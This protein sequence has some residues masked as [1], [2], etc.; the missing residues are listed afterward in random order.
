MQPFRKHT[1]K[2]APLYRANI[3]TDQI[4][5]KQFL[6]RIERTG[7][8]EFLFNDWRR[9][10]N[11]QPEPGFVL[12]QPQY[13]GASILVAGK[14]F[15]CGSSREHAVWALA[16][17]GFRAVIASSF[18]D[19][20]ANNCVK[21]GVLTVALSE[22]EA[23]GIARRASDTP[24][25]QLTIDLENCSV[26]DEQGLMASFKIDEFTRHCLLEGLDDIGLTLQHQADISG[27]EAK[28]PVPA[29]WKA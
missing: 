22:E 3:D 18:A 17:Y 13:T 14:N 25:Y 5:P 28:H 26:R 24:N 10:A 7:F 2:V 8:G 1:G 9:T 6:K 4:I 20:F 29:A 11:G 15:G 19:I 27:Y 16:D 21:N 12:N 23:A